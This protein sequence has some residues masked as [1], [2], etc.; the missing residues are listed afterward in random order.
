MHK[1]TEAQREASR[2]PKYDSKDSNKVSLACILHCLMRLGN[3]SPALSFC[4]H[5][6]QGH[7]P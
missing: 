5:K 6:V 3:K 1:E 4:Q 7:G 2:V